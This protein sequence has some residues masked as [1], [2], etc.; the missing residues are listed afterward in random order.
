MLES[1]ANF[2]IVF[3][4]TDNEEINHPKSVFMN[5]AANGKFVMGP[6]WDFDWAY[7]YEGTEKHFSHYQ[8][9]WTGTK[10][11]AGFFSRFL[12]PGYC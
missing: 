4:L 9:F 6:V 2:L 1:I 8:S 7:G 3:M 10:A 5:K 12:G 11:K